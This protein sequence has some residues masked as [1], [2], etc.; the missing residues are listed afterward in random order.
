MRKL[1][2]AI[3]IT[4]DGCCDHTK[5]APADDMMDHFI[6]LLQETDLF[7]YGRK[8]YELMIP[9]WPDVAKD[10]SSDKSDRDYALAFETADKV[11]FSRTLKGVDDKKSRLATAG[12]KE[13]ILRLKALPGKNMLASG[14]DLPAQMIALGL[15][16]EFHIV[17][18]PLVIGQGRRLLAET[19]LPHKQDL[20][21]IRTETFASGCVA[22][23]Y[24]K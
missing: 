14:V 11:V 7:V 13:E 9:Y 24:A 6:Q 20:K 3:N 21:L 12:L 18:H 22:L 10:P 4:L 5:F 17:I 2:Y 23:R 1:I 8:T 15:V 16:D 19:I